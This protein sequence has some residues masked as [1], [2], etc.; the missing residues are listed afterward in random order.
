M[1]KN[2]KIIKYI[3]LKKIKQN[4]RKVKEIKNEINESLSKIDLYKHKLKGLNEYFNDIIIHATNEIEYYTKIFEIM[5][6]SLD[7]LKNYESINNINNFRAKKIN[8]EIELFL[9]ENLNNKFKYL[10]N[11]YNLEGENIVTLWYVDNCQ[12]HSCY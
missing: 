11:K 12:C 7:N 3:H 9:K 5:S 4:E 6:Y 10:I 8:K 1:K 2:I